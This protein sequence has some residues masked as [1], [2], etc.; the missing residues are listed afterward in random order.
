MKWEHVSVNDAILAESIDGRISVRGTV[1]SLSH[2]YGR[3]LI[4]SVDSRKHYCASHFRLLVHTVHRKERARTDKNRDVLKLPND[5]RCD[6]SDSLREAILEKLIETGA[7]MRV[8]ELAHVIDRTPGQAYQ[9]LKILIL[10]GKVGR[11]GVK[12]VAIKR[13]EVAA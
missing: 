3:G 4:F 11:S 1:L 10:D 8:S 6:R 5:A 13:R 12:Y 2:V 9:H 7:P